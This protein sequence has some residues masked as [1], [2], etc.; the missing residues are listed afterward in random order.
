MFLQQQNMYLKLES[1]NH[2]F[3]EFVKFYY[4]Y[5]YAELLVQISSSECGKGVQHKT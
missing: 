5:D 4:A 3:I 1:G 2:Y